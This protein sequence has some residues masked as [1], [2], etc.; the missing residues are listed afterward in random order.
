MAYREDIGTLQPAKRTDDGRL[1]VDALFGRTGVQTYYNADGSPR[2]EYRPPSEVF[3]PAS[4]SSLAFVPVTDDH[5]P[6]MVSSS[7]SAEYTIGQVGENIR[8]EGI[9]LAGRMTV[10]DA[11]VV[12][13][14][15]AGKREVSCGYDCD[16]VMQPG[17]T[18][19]G[20]RYD[21]MQTNIVYNH[22][23]IVDAGRAGS[24]KVRMDRAG[25][26]KRIGHMDAA[27][28]FQ[29]G[30]HT[31]DVTPGDAG[32]E[33]WVY[34]TD[35]TAR[36]LASAVS[37]ALA[38][39]PGITVAAGDPGQLVRFDRAIAVGRTDASARSFGA[40]SVSVKV[41]SLTM[42]PDQLTVTLSAA[43]SASPDF[44]SVR[45][46]SK[47]NPMT[48]L[49]KAQAHIIEL[50]K[51]LGAE[52]ARADKAE[53]KQ[54]EHK[55][56][57]QAAEAKQTE[58][59]AKLANETKRAD[60]AEASLK[61]VEKARTD[62]AASFAAAVSARAELLST[63]VQHLGRTDA[64][65]VKSPDGKGTI[66]LDT[67][68]DRDIRVAIVKKLDGFDIPAERSD[69]TVQTV[70]DSAIARAPKTAAALGAAQTLIFKGNLDGA[71][72]PKPGDREA[73]ARARMDKA[74]A[75]AWRSKTVETK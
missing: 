39:H 35:M 17:V 50:T 9:H 16:L 26:V 68:S 74:H 45:T 15:D 1:I 36:D 40:S 56:A 8:R 14:M 51:Q 38:G 47:E 19:E 49:E 66:K 52:T 30:A 64:G 44:Q 34:S 37:R 18:P 2:V 71:G 22:L 46:D 10:N 25:T 72:Q 24:A 63:A 23:A 75:E 32:V 60:T 27:V 28:S 12:R 21:A 42:T 59:E 48:E 55:D 70:C 41:S 43:L 58:A 29:N 67:M 57:K 5:P 33:A 7:N 3:K 69:E 54:K 6:V 53:A 73:E 20:E 62:A 4:M 61:T 31:V 65:E 13:K 11:T